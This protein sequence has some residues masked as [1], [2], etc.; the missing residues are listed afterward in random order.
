MLECVV[1]TISANVYTKIEGRIMEL[2]LVAMIEAMGGWDI[3][4]R[5]GATVAFA[6]LIQAGIHAKTKKTLSKFIKLGTAFVASAAIS[7]AWGSEGGMLAKDIF[8]T[9][10]FSTFVWTNVIKPIIVKFGKQ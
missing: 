5:V 6:Y 8:V 4:F 1:A 10:F 2:T 9:F 7:L 3:V